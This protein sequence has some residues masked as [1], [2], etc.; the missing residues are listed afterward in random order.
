MLGYDRIYSGKETII[1]M[2][3]KLKELQEFLAKNNLTLL[4]FLETQNGEQ[5]R[6][7]SVVPKEL[8]QLGWRPVLNLAPV[9]QKP[10]N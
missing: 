8:L 10:T 1:I 2:D 3:E 7:E 6:V 4:M 9:Q 5:I